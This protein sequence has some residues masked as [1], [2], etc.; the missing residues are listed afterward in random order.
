[1]VVI[2]FYAVLF[3]L[4]MVQVEGQSHS[5][6]T[7]VYWTLVT[8]ST[9]GFGDVTFTTDIGRLFSLGVLMSG[10]VLLLMVLPF[11]FIRFF[12]APWLEAQVRLLAPRRVAS[13]VRDHLIISRHD[14]IAAALIERLKPERIPYYV[15]ESDPAAAAH[16]LGQGV[17]VITGRARQPDNLRRVAG[18]AG[19]PTACQLRGHDEHQYHVDGS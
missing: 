4:I 18:A 12:Y 10:V 19:A 2:L 13:S 5:W 11:T 6:I 14:E 3:Q 1:M 7:A 16:L 15:V 9:L 17:S 8:M